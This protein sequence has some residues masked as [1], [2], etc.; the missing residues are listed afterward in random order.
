[1]EVW[2]PI[3]VALERPVTVAVARKL[4]ASR[5]RRDV[6]V[7]A[8]GHLRDRRTIC[9]AAGVPRLRTRTVWLSTGWGSAEGEDV[10]QIS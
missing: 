8:V 1:M 4:W 3:W 7:V 9:V 10:G 6:G 2:V 5:S